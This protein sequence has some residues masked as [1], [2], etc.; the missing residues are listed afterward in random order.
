[1]RIAIVGSGISGLGAAFIL[2][3]A[4]HEVTV[5]EKESKLGGHTLTDNSAGVP[6]DLGFQ[7]FNLT[8][9]PHLV[10]MLEALRVDSEPSD[11]SFGLSVDGGALEWGSGRGTPGMLGTF[12]SIFAQRS[13]LCSASF[14]RMLLE[15]VRFGRYAPEVIDPK[16]AS[17]W[18]GRT[19]G[20]YLSSKGYSEYFIHCYVEPMCAAIWSAPRGAMLDSPV[21]PLV[22]FWLNHHLLDIFTTRPTWRAVVGRSQAYVAAIQQ[23]LGPKRFMLGQPVT[24]VTRQSNGGVSVESKA[25]SGYTQVER[26]DHVLLAC[27][28]DTSLKVLGNSAT[29]EEKSILEAIPYSSSDIYLHAD[30]KLM[31]IR[32][33]AWASWNVLQ[34]AVGSANGSKEADPVCV[35]YWVNSLQRCPED[36]KDIFVTLNPPSP[37]EA[38]KTFLKLNLA[39]PQYGKESEEAQEKVSQQ[40]GHGGVWL[41]GAWTSSG[42]HEDGL[43]SAVEVCKKLGVPLPWQPIATSPKMGSI[44]ERLSFEAFKRMVQ[45]AMV[46]GKLRVILP[47]GTEFEAQGSQQIGDEYHFGPPGANQTE[48]TMRVLNWRFFLR[49]LR[50][51]DIGLGEAYIDGDFE[52]RGEGTGVTDFMRILCRNAPHIHAS[53]TPAVLGFIG[54]AAQS[55]FGVVHK[56]AHARRANTMEGSKNNISYH[57][58]EGNDFF[59]LFLDRSLMYSCGVHRKQGTLSNAV[60]YSVSL[61]DSQDYKVD[62]VLQRAG[63]SKGKHILEIGCG[64]GYCALRAVQKYGCEWTGIT[65]SMEQ[66]REATRR[67]AEAGLSDK[68]SFFYWD[69]RQAHELPTR[70]AA[71]F[72]A[73]VSIEML[74]AVGHENLPDYFAAL[75]RALKPGAPAAVQVITIPDERYE[76]YC[77]SSDFIREHIFPGGHLPSLGAMQEAAQSALGGAGTT[78]ASCDNIG[79]DYAVTLRRWRERLEEKRDVAVQRGYVDKLVRKYIFYFSYCEAAFETRYLHDYVL[80]WETPGVTVAQPSA[81]KARARGIMPMIAVAASVA[82]G[83]YALIQAS[84]RGGFNVPKIV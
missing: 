60:D 81:E 15:V 26:Y 7:V 75:R 3:S 69:Y 5:Y 34:G 8:T 49:L 78:L 23:R 51:Q 40:T 84:R 22:R 42:F 20:D 73:V 66:L 46:V 19:L 24:S 45:R 57:Y 64:W 6:V 54:S 41:L 68:I 82:C 67:V 10:G 50:S 48:A 35:S 80:R 12:R 74:E 59:D 37:P 16:T 58:D 39:H 70:P 2:H 33:D 43:R 4:G 56:L 28:T 71:G 18:Q 11:M 61:E 30:E 83:T 38:S 29:A 62:L 21:Q 47:D 53:Q 13:N 36:T 14:W 32:R 1:M 9:Y 27:H 44:M 65:L 17:Q 76:G 63:V 52:V 55:A 72:D 31:P 25:A 79:P 77:N